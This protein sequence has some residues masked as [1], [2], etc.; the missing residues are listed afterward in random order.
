M[1]NKEMRK[2]EELLEK[3]WNT[4]CIIKCGLHFIQSHLFEHYLTRA[5]QDEQRLPNHAQ[6]YREYKEALR[7]QRNNVYKVR[8]NSHTPSPDTPPLSG[9]Q[10][11]EFGRQLL[12]QVPPQQ[13][14]QRSE[15]IALYKPWEN[16]P[17]HTPISDPPSQPH[18]S[19]F[20]VIGDF[21]RPLSLN[22]S[23][24]E[25]NKVNVK[26]V[27]KEAVLSYVKAKT[28]PS[29]VIQPPPFRSPTTELLSPTLPYRSLTVATSPTTESNNPAPP[30]RPPPAEPPT[31]SRK[32]APVKAKPSILSRQN[33]LTNSTNGNQTPP[34]SNPSHTAVTASFTVRREMERQREEMEQIQHLRQVINH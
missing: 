23:H 12:V 13:P 26:A 6:T 27:Q 17:N 14:Q 25:N 21:S 34:P 10:T 5:S 20:A 7:Q 19:S 29:S 16:S 8:D 32:I 3:F 22:L 31:G 11:M 28:S 2:G 4:K 9:N 15:G 1:M 33:S 30:Y 18:P 24:D